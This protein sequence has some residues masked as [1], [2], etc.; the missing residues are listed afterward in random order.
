MT[1]PTRSCPRCQCTGSMIAGRT[2]GSATPSVRWTCRHC[3][4]HYDTTR[5]YWAF[6]A[7]VGHRPASPSPSPSRRTATGDLTRASGPDPSGLGW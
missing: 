7:L 6:A 1:I 4:H 5:D 2:P 3:R